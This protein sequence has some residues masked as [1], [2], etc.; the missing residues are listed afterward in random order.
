MMIK[1]PVILNIKSFASRRSARHGSILLAALLFLSA[2]AYAQNSNLQLLPP[3]G[4]NSATVCSTTNQLLSFNSAPTAGSAITCTKAQSD[5]KGNIT[6]PGTVTP[7]NATTG[8]VCLSEGALAYDIVNHNPVFCNSSLIWSVMG[9]EA[10]SWITAPTGVSEN[11]WFQSYSS[12]P[13][14]WCSTAGYNRATGA[15]ISIQANPGNQPNTVSQGVLVGYVGGINENGNPTGN[16]QF[17]CLGEGQPTRGLGGQT[18]PPAQT[19]LPAARILC[20]K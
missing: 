9:S 10:S 15:C 14:A 11:E 1:S 18:F 4:Q 7:G 20:V 6:T 13:D 19:F 5:P 2:G 3:T 17:T 16:S 8:G 12:T